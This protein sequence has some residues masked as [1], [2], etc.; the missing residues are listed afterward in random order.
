MDL[1]TQGLVGASIPL[2][3]SNKKQLGA[4]GLAGFLAGMAPDLDALIRSPTDGLLF[5][6]YHRQF[7]HSFLFIP[8]GG[9]IVALVLFPILNLR[10]RVGFLVLW[11]WC[12]LGFGTHGILDAATSY[13]TQ[14]L[15]PFSEA[16]YAFR[17][18]SIV[19]PIFSIPIL[20]GILASIFLKKKKWCI[21][22]V[23][24]SL[25][26]LVFANIQR[27]SAHASAEQLASA[28]GHIPARLVVKPTFGNTF[29]WRS[30]YEF[31]GRFYV[32]AIRTVSGALQVPG[33]SIEKLNVSEQFPWLKEGTQ[34]R[35]DLERFA[36]FS[37]GFIAQGDGGSDTVSDI[38][39]SFLPNTIEPLW[40]IRLRRD[41]SDT[42]HVTY[43]T[44]REKP[45]QK[46][47]TLVKMIFQ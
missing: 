27:D 17:L 6:E 15:W 36:R 37:D 1:L 22:A 21:S 31:D 11:L 25:C 14:L 9:A 18:I 5:L 39:Y 2:I 46:F 7:T 29:L 28:R 10:R 4:A 35:E 42:Q 19:D 38:R 34:Q 23:I 32:D 24:W 43:E 3:L 13:G 41:A 47:S 16:R 45:A 12:C 44:H 33:S 8:I 30:I 20:I 40:S 26:Y